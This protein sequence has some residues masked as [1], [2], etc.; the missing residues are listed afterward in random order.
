MDAHDAGDVRIIYNKLLGGWYVVR[1]PNDTP[2]GGRFESK[3]AAQ[4][5]LSRQGAA[6]TKPAPN[7]QLSVGTR[8]KINAPG[9]RG[10]GET[11]KIINYHPSGGAWVSSKPGE[12]T[13]YGPFRPEQ[14]RP[15]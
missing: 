3:E 9:I 6:S 15:V 13:N 8:V 4:A 14:L 1:G 12:Y 7:G 10:N 2:I 11:G 5:S